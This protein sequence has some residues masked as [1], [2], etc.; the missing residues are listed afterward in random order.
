VCSVLRQAG[1]KGFAI[2]LAHGMQHLSRLDN[3]HE[4]ILLAEL[5]NY[6]ERVETAAANLEPH[7]LATWLRD[8]ANAFHTYYNS[9]QFLV[10]DADLRNARLALVVATRQVL[11]NGLDL[12]GL[13]APEKM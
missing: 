8:L 10:E 11:K 1:E 5:A 13:S 3:E 6:P 2:D 7:L 4:Q 9:H 12:L